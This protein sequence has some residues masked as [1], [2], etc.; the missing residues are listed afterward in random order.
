MS[1]EKFYLIFSEQPYKKVAI[2]EPIGYSSV[3]FSLDQRE[4]G[5]GRDV[6]LSGGKF[7]FRFTRHRHGKAFEDI[8]YYAHY[9]GFESDIKLI[10][11]LEDLTEFI[12]ELDFVTAESNDYDYFSCAVIMESETQIFRRRNDT[13]VDLFANVDTN[14]EAI[15]PLDP[16]N[17]L[18]QAKPNIQSS[19]WEQVSESSAFILIIA[20][21]Y[22]NITQSLIKSDIN[23]SYVP[24]VYRSQQRSDMQILLA[25]SN[26]KNVV[27]NIKN[28]LIELRTDAEITVAISYIKTSGEVTN[29][30]G[31]STQ[32]FYFK[33]GNTDIT[34]DFT[35][36]IGDM[37][38]GEKLYLYMRASTSGASRATIK[39]CDVEITSQSTAY[40]SIV[41]CFHVIDAL[42]QIAKSTSGL[43][44]YAPRYEKGGELYGTVI[45][46][47]KLLGGNTTD[48]F[49]VSWEDLFEKSISPEQNADS[50]I[51]IDK[52]VFCGIEDDYY[53]NEECGFFPNTQFSGLVR[54]PNPMYC[55][56]SFNFKYENYQ[57]LKENVEPNS[58]STIHGQSILTPYNQKAENG[59]ELSVKWIRDAILLDVQQ[60]LS[61]KV[62]KDTATQDDDKIFAIDTLETENDQSFTESTSLQ[63]SYVGNT[64]PLLAYLSL[65]NNGEVNFLVL[66]IR[67]GAG[68]AI[69]YPDPNAGNYEVTAV[70][71]TEVQIKRISGGSISNANDGIRLTKY[72]YEIKQA[73][74]PLTNRTNQ[75]FTYVNN[76]LSPERYSNL[77]YSVERNI[78]RFW[79][80]FIATIN[81]Y[82]RDKAVRNTF[83]KNN[84]NCETE[85]AGLRI[86]E[87]EDFFTEDPI[88]TAYKYD[89]VVFANV[90]HS[91]FIDLQNQIRVKRGFI[92]T[93]DNKKRVLKLY[94]IKMSYENRT[95]QL[96]M[97]GQ[98][99]YE[100]VF[101][102]ITSINGLITINNE[103]IL[104]KIYYDPKVLMRDKELILYDAQKQLLYNPIY[105]NMISINGVLP[106]TIEILKEILDLL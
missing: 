19:K 3:D 90:E 86:K 98:E 60:R 41:P 93:I 59:K 69:E 33:G 53:T 5:M 52:R 36:N 37:Q 84:G 71:N 101:M 10:I 55:S 74:I 34:Q 81:M 77:I 58:E 89:K 106:E 65:K 12:G 62:S 28:T 13:K 100:K 68:F 20:P 82:H 17:M 23:D 38:R 61:T 30:I 44:V 40:N 85:Y 104:R 27:L 64:D 25:E 22:F 88:V 7:N 45:T 1:K 50:E 21:N 32:I 4:N 75:G 99:K 103:T 48:P 42:K 79:K 35:V 67:I 6:T 54:I 92:R 29:S 96:T 72:T 83:Y 105:W 47:G 15:T 43:D 51:Q 18:L 9:Y 70:F 94:P 91:K 57:S 26:L 73:T 66:G 87:K 11:V 14:G 56:N 80:K 76:L 46:S 49:Y 24:F 78:R 31:S 97:S 102:T 63:H 39:K 2:N 16:V 95:R 8:L